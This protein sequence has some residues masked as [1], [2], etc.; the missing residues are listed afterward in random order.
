MAENKVRNYEEVIAKIEA[1]I[2]GETDWIAILS[3]V[4]CELHNAFE[5]YHWT[6]FYRVTAPALLQ[7]GPYQGSHGC[8]RIPF[9]KGVCGKAAS[10]RTT[11]LVADVMSLPYHIACSSTTQ[12]EIVVPVFNPQG[13]VVAVFDVDSNHPA[14]FDATDQLFLEKIMNLITPQAPR[15]PAS[16]GA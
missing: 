4:V 16:S 8:L 9:A 10:E 1:L 5:Y 15:V 3:T 6:G 11:Q 2:A 13:E 14:A 7:V 12:S